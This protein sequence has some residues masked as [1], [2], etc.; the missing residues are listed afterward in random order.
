MGSKNSGRFK[1]VWN[2]ERQQFIINNA[3]IMSDA[4]MARKLSVR[5]KY[6]FTTAAVRQK[7]QLLG[8]K[9]KGGRGIVQLYSPHRKNNR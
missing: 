2:H 3:T 7:R 5:S 4:E 6:D 9:K 8:L 1:N